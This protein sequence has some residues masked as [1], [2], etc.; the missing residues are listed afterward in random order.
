MD[1]LNLTYS[2]LKNTRF[3]GGKEAIGHRN[4]GGRDLDYGARFYDAQIGRWHTIDPL[5]EK[6]YSISPYAYVANNPINRVDPDGRD[7]WDFMKGF[8]HSVISN[9]YWGAVHPNTGIVSNANHYN[10]GRNAGDLISMVVGA[11]EANIGAIAAA[12]GAV[13]TVASAGTTAPATVPVAVAGVAAAIHGTGVA[14]TAAK[15]LANQEGR[16]SET[17]DSSSGRGSN[18]LK[19]DS[20][21]QGDHSTF[22]TGSDGKTTNTATYKQNPQNPTGFDEVKRVD[23]QGSTHKNGAGQDVPTPHVHEKGVKY[24]RPARPEELPRQ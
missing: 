21:A 16:I 3:S 4:F 22:R 18:H 20:N 6:Y 24:A 10:A 19:P 11:T 23:I 2:P 15:S 12:G 9:F 8:A 7:A 14:M 13:A 1:C 17:S 5:A